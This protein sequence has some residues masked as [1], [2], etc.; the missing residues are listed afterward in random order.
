[1]K[2]LTVNRAWKGRRYKTDEYTAF[3]TELMYRLPPKLRGFDPENKKMEIYL[4]FGVSN[5]GADWDN[6]IKPFVDVL[7]RK[8]GFNDKYIFDAIVKKR[9]VP[10]GEEYIRFEIG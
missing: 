5:S 4:E 9:I 2:P 1:M 7:Q 8:Y 3:E 10:R 6:P